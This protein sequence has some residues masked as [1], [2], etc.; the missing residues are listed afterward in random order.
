MWNSPKP[1]WIHHKNQYINSM[2]LIVPLIATFL[3]TSLNF[4][5]EPK[6]CEVHQEKMTLKAVPIRY[7][8][9]AFDSYDQKMRGAEV[10]LFPHALDHVEGGCVVSKERTESVSECASCRKKK[11]AWLLKNPRPKS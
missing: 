7:G 1:A 11:E 5:A 9:P 8:M 10:R 3:A 6:V 4:A 2:R